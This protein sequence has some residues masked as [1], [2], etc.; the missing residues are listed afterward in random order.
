MG[1]SG[2]EPFRRLAVEGSIEDLKRGRVALSLNEPR[3]AEEGECLVEGALVVRGW[4]HARGGIE[5]VVVTVDGRRYEALRP[6]VRTDLLDYYGPAAAAEGGFALRLHPT[7]CPP[8]RHRVAVIATGC[9]GDAVGVEG[10]IVFR[11]D[12]LDADTPPDRGLSVDWLDERATPRPA[13]APTETYDPRRHAGTAREAEHRLRYLWARELADGR[14]VLDARCGLGWG[15]T[16]LS[17]AG[18]SR[19]VGVDPGTDAIELARR[20]AAEAGVDVELAVGDATSL[21][22]DDASFD[23]VTWFE[24]PRPDADTSGVVTELRRVLRPD[25]ILVA[26]V[27]DELAGALGATFA[28]VRAYRQRTSLASVLFDDGSARPGGGHGIEEASLRG[29]LRGDLDG[30]RGDVVAL[31]TDGIPPELGPAAA[32]AS[33][34]AIERVHGLA[35]MWESRA[36][37]A[38]ADA[39]ASRVEAGLASAQQEAAIRMLREA[40]ARLRQVEG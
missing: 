37:V 24:E 2:I 1:V 30:D 23:L 20:R 34:A 7:E 17:E 19:V 27:H 3:L 13:P 26:S 31:A 29:V 11:P 10:D 12:P 32:F 25:G 28:H 4:A 39:A 22:F 18:A 35:R 21:P 14:D 36:L 6:I 5:S 40:E 8:G 9:E 15:A 38:E 16:C 33:P